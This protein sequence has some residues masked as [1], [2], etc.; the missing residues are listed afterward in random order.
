MTRQTLVLNSILGMTVHRQ[1]VCDAEQI[2]HESFVCRL[3]LN[4][5]LALQQVKS[6]ERANG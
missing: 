4:V 5:I 1:S 6:S 3:R 2:G